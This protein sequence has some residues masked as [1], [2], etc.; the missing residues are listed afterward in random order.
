MRYK[1]VKTLIKK[2]L[3]D[4]IRDKKAVIMML[5]VPLVIYPLIFFGT[6]AVMSAI[7]MGM[8]KNE[9]KVVVE[10]AINN[11]WDDELIAAIEE[12]NNPKSEDSKNVDDKTDQLKI[13]RSNEIWNYGKASKALQAEEIDA[14]VALFM[15]GEDGRPEYRIIYVSSIT[16]SSYAADILKN[17]L[18][19][20]NRSESERMIEDSGMDPELTLTPIVIDSRDIASKEQTT[21]NL[22]GM[23]LPMLLIISLLMGTMYPA[24]DTT[25]GEKERGTLE[26]LLTLPVTNREIII[27]KFFTVAVIGIVSAILNL[28]SMALMGVYMIKLIGGLGITTEAVK[29]GKFL[30]A[31]AVTIFAVL[32]FSLFI[33]AITM[34]IAAFA[35][36]YKEANNYITPMTL[37]VMLTGYIAFIPNIELDRKMA[38]V[39]VANICLLIKNILNFKYEMEIVALVLLSNIIYAILAVL[40]LGRV[41]NSEGILFDEGRSGIQLFEKRSNMKKGGVPTTG[42][43]W[44]LVCIVFMAVIYIGSLLQLKWGFGGVAGIQLMILLIPLLFVIYTKRS[45]KETYSFKKP[46]V[47]VFFGGVLL[48]FGT[49]FL[50]ILLTVFTSMLFP[51]DAETAS[52]GIDTTLSG[53]G[54]LITLFVVALMPA[55]CEEMMFRGF[56]FSAFRK[57]YKITAAILLVAVL[58]GVYHMSVVRFFTTALLGAALAITVYY[59]GSIFPAMLMHFCNN[60]VAVLQMFYP[61]FFINHVPILGEEKLSIS[62]AIILFLLGTVL[63]TA[64]ILLLRRN[65]RGKEV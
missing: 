57:K 50:G 62:S 39:P 30:P 64:G 18:N 25:A 20:M 5:I 26:T 56:I 10:R 43:A 52:E 40:F 3:L 54:F 24:I 34:C 44:F 49:L 29:L 60:G 13:V 9:Y 59:S 32:V 48:V 41:Y 22:L 1:V 45:V 37:V 4:V 15:S 55:I 12:H 28:L 27:G 53:H 61:E 36:S 46:T 8:E 23:V 31:I 35:K 2:E 6:M 16:N 58:F 19:R 11:K 7:Q 38:L 51:A 47:T 33:S 14:Y 63:A 65:H 42:D 21:G 17:I